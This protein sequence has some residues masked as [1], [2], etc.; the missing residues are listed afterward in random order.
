MKAKALSKKINAGLGILLSLLQ[1]MWTATRTRLIELVNVPDTTVWW[2][3][4]ADIGGMT[5]QGS[6]IAGRS[7]QYSL[8]MPML[9]AGIRSVTLAE[10]LSRFI[11][12]EL[13]KKEGRDSPDT[14]ILA[15]FSAEVCAICT[16][17]NRHGMEIVYQTGAVGTGD[18][19][20]HII[21]NLRVIK[22][23]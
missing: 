23:M 5:L 17:A 12:V 13:N 18:Q 1:G 4:G 7:V 16:E 9:V 20:Q 11:F 22:V 3:P 8:R 19:Q 21:S 15:K 14:S 6:N 10:D 2:P